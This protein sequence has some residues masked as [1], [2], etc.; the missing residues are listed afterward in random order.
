M[1]HKTHVDTVLGFRERYLSKIDA[2]ESLQQY[3]HYSG[4][5]RTTAVPYDRVSM[6]IPTIKL[7]AAYLYDRAL[8]SSAISAKAILGSL[9]DILHASFVS[10]VGN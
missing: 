6:I 3:L 1:K 2:K 4:K 7:E 9:L 5:V 10:V 8:V